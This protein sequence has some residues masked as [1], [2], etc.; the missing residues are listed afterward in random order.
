MTLDQPSFCKVNLLLN[1]LARRPDGYHE[2]ETV[3]HPVNLH[4]HLSFERQGSRVHL[5]CNDPL[6]PVNSR[7]LVFAAAEHFLK[8]AGIH[9]GVRIR[10]EKHI[11]ISA[12]LGG[13]S[14]NAAATLQALNELFGHPLDA[15]AL[16]SLAAALGSDVP[17]LPPKPPSPR[18]R[19]RRDDRAR[20]FLSRL[21]PLLAGLG[22]SRLGISIGPAYEHLDRQPEWLNGQPGRARRL[23]D[24]LQPPTWLRRGPSF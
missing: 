18:H 7:N 3:M 14:G 10:L 1:I 19:A 15:A 16:A 22:A 9:E 4:D 23:L 13:G 24:S 17:F 12:G 2:L 21:G 11:P 20:G 6:L 8:A 5:S